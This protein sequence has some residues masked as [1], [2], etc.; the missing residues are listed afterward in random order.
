MK[1]DGTTDGLHETI[2]EIERLWAKSGGLFAC[3]LP[4]GWRPRLH[5]FIDGSL[6][7]DRCEV[8]VL[9]GFVAEARCPLDAWREDG[10]FIVANHPVESARASDCGPEPKFGW[11]IW[12]DAGDCFRIGGDTLPSCIWAAMPGGDR[13]PDRPSRKCYESHDAADEA[14]RAGMVIWA[15]EEAARRGL[16]P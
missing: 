8:R 7:P 1:R 9:R 10:P 14:L 6:Y 15:R 5:E 3:P 12:H 11:W 13:D 16:V 4:L 2:V